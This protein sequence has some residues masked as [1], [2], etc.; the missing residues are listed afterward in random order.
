MGAPVCGET[1]VKG[2]L[3]ALAVKPMAAGL[4]TTLPPRR[5]AAVRV[6]IGTATAGAKAF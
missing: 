3:I 6:A 4:P 2:I 1:G 5:K